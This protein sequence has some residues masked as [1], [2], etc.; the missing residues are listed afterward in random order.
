MI[1]PSRQRFG[2]IVARDEKDLDLAEAA[3]LIACEEYPDLDVGLYLSRLNELGAG[4]RR[5]VAAAGSL[6]DQVVALS[7]YLAGHEGFHGNVDEYYDPRNSFLNDVL[8]RKL[9]I[10]ITLSAVYMEVGRRA[11]LDIQGVSF[12]GHFLVKVETDDGDLVIDPFHGG[13]LLS[14]EDCQKRLDRVYGGKVQLEASLLDPAGPKQMLSRM[15]RNLKAIYVRAEELPRALGVLDMLLLL[16]PGSAE[17]LRDR[18]LL[19]AA[20]D[21]YAR[22]AADLESFLTLT[23]AAPEAA[24]LADKILELRRR[25]ARLN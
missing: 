15:L 18:G 5:A 2:Q 13:T 20:L 1:T 21:C 4:A 8:D 24:S 16:D 12:P 6:D 23:P 25:A 9:G 7:A 10:P 17:D 3:L 14:A 11:G 22:A 19:Y